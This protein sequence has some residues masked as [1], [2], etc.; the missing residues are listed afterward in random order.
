MNGTDIGSIAFDCI[1]NSFHL[2]LVD[3]K[4]N[5]DNIEEN[6]TIGILSGALGVMHQADVDMVVE[7]ID[8]MIEEVSE[9]NC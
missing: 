5:R 9:N 1:R 2:P 4:A 6:I 3:G 8:E 7:V